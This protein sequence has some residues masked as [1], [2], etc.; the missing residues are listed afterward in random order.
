MGGGGGLANFLT[1]AVFFATV[2]KHLAQDCCNFVTVIVS[3]LHIIWYTFWSTAV[4]IVARFSTRVWL[5][6]TKI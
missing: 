5:K 3:L 4:A 2:Q 6:M 1:Q